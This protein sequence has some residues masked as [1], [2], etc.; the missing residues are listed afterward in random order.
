MLGYFYKMFS[1]R[2]RWCLLVL[3]MLGLSGGLGEAGSPAIT[4][5]ISLNKK[6]RDAHGHWPFQIGGENIL[7]V[8]VP[9]PISSLKATLIAPD[10]TKI[11]LAATTLSPDLYTLTLGP[12]LAK[13]EFIYE[14]GLVFAKGYGLE[15]SLM[16]GSDEA[17]TT[18]RLQQ[19]PDKKFAAWKFGEPV[20]STKGYFTLGAEEKF[21]FNPA[22][23]TGVILDYFLGDAVLLDNRKVT[24]FASLRPNAPQDAMDFQLRVLNIDGSALNTKPVTLN[25]GKPA[26]I[27]VFDSGDW[28]QGRYRFLLEPV[29]EGKVFQDGV[30]ISYRR[31]SVQDSNAWV[32]PVLPWRLPT[33]PDGKALVINQFSGSETISRPKGWEIGELGSAVSNGASEPLVIRPQLE[34]YYAVYMTPLDRGCLISVGQEKMVRACKLDAEQFVTVADLT[35]QDIR[36]YGFDWIEKAS[37]KTGLRSLRFEPVTTG[38]AAMLATMGRP[39]LHLT[40]IDDWMEYFHGAARI[41]RDQIYAILRGQQEVGLRSVAWS[42]GRSLVEYHSALPSTTR[43]PAQR[44]SDVEA[45]HPTVHAYKSREAMINLLC[46]FRGALEAAS[47]LDLTLEAW[48]GM[49]RHYGAD[50]LDGIFTSKWF[51]DHQEWRQWRKNAD[52]PNRGEVC[53]YFPG[54]REERL[55]ILGELVSIG[56]R[57]LTLDTTRQ[58]PMMLYHPQMVEAYIKE[59]GRDPRTFGIE[60]PE[61]YQHWITWRSQFFTQLLRDL[62]QA[63]QNSADGKSTTINVRVPQSDITTNLAMGL[64]IKTWLK[65]GLIDQ[66]LLNPLEVCRGEGLSRIGEYKLLCEAAKVQ[67]SVGVGATWMSRPGMPA[68]LRRAAGLQAAGIKAIDLYEAEYLAFLTDA[69]WVPSVMGSS[70]LLGEFLERSNLE[71]C[72]PILPETACLGTDN[73]SRWLETGWTLK[74]AEINSL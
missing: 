64:D 56:A 20:N 10:G 9:L 17:V 12:L 18:L 36:I 58:I 2:M 29:Q 8:R 60:R 72:Y 26:P 48:L 13:L 3:L 42:T 31:D 21:R 6:Q 4:P 24:V 11:P 22:E 44:L 61:D 67:L 1:A 33:R 32:S 43:F 59:Y 30:S 19:V 62:H 40:G 53:Y 71:A 51:T 39:D 55:A 70:K 57:H 41:H 27:A 45:E 15:I 16:G 25:K 34:G 47:E 68:G 23:S 14:E 28:Q 69:R 5:E 52:K 65:E 66:L 35:G 46:P 50:V 63:V 37:K 7:Q 38:A 74:G 54:V 49:N 73:H